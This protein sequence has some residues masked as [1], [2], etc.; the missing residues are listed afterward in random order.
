MVTATFPKAREEELSGQLKSAVLSTRLEQGARLDPEAN[1]PFTL[2]VSK[3]LKV[4]PAINK[5]LLYTKDGV[6]PTKSPKD[7]LFVAAPSLGKV[8]AGDKRQ[9]AE[10]RLRQTAE[11]KGLTV[12]STNPV[13][14]AGLE[15]YESVAKAE[16]TQSGIPLV[17]YQAI[18]F[19]E[20]SYI[21]M[22]G[23]V[24]TELGEQY[25]PAFKEMARSLKRKQP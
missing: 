19:D 6:I 20:S 17:V 18:L 2:S 10:Q 24:G 23:L 11:T 12:E 5:A 4:T 7:P 22:Q 14:I 9:F 15:G 1:L 3:R 13:T 16:D 8:T 25:L 21:L